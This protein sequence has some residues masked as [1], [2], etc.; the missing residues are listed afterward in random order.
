MYMCDEFHFARFLT[1]PPRSASK[2]L[3]LKEMTDI[4]KDARRVFNLHA[5]TCVY[6]KNT[7]MFANMRWKSHDYLRIKNELTNV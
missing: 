7:F 3:H 5:K 4:C 2:N 6:T 1:L